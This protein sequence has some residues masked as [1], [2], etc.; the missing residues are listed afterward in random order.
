MSRYDETYAAWQ[1]DPVGFWEAAGLEIDW[2]T[3]ATQ[4]FNPDKGVY[5][6]WFDGATCNTCF[7]CL[8]RHVEAGAAM[9]LRSFMTARSQ[10]L[11]RASRFR[12]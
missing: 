1:N 3:P 5:G 12:R 6:R 10:T 9:T 7:N 2:F 4:V 11:S 8:D